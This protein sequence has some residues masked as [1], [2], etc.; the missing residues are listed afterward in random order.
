MSGPLA[1]VRVLEAGSFIAGPYAA[2]LL[3]ATI[4]ISFPLLSA[5]SERR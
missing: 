4:S 5:E 3:G 1:G 2:M